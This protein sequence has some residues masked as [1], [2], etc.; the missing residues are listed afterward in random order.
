M[1]NDAQWHQHARMLMDFVC[2]NGRNPSKYKDEERAM[3]HWLKY[4]KKRRKAGMMP[5]ER[6][7]LFD[8]LLQTM[9]KHRHVN[10]YV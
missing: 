6:L 5:P 4:N 9:E 7:R 3:L 8:E 2:Q 10:Q 1:N